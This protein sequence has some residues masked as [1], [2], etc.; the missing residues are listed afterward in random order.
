MVKKKPN[1]VRFELPLHLN[2]LLSHDIEGLNDLA[3]NKYAVKTGSKG[4]IL[5]DISY[6]PI[7]I[8]KDR[9]IILRVNATKENS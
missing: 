6:T 9:L 4:V 3:D 1:R 2:D 5:S 7:G 8:N